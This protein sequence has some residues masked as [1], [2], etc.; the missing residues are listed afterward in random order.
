MGRGGLKMNKLSFKEIMNLDYKFIFDYFDVPL[1][2]IGES[3]KRNYL[4]YYIDDETFFVSELKKRDVIQLDNTKNLKK[5]MEYLIEIEKLKIMKF[6]F[7]EDRVE[8]ISIEQ[9]D[10]DF[11]KYLPKSNKVIDYDYNLNIEIPKEYSFSRHLKFLLETE[12]M[13]VR[14][15]DQFNSEIYNIEVI[16]NVMKYVKKSFDTVKNAAQ[17]LGEVINQ[18]LMMSPNTVGSFK[19]N[20]LMSDESNLLDDKIDFFPILNVIDEVTVQNRQLNLDII[21]DEVG[22]ELINNVR[23]F[24][25]TVKKESIAIEFYENKNSGEQLARLSSNS[26]IDNNL[27][28]FKDKIKEKEQLTVT[29]EEIKLKNSRFITGSVIYNSVKIDVDGV[30]KKAK[31]QTDLF[32]RIK[33][34]TQHLSLDKPIELDLIIETSKDLQENLV[35]EILIIDNFKYLEHSEKD[36]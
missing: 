27:N 7:S 23:E 35:K 26:F 22:V 5:F 1:S 33:N 17:T 12:N 15:T 16:E 32:K 14:I 9:A 2:F 34:K 11:K 30:T 19:I 13:T 4:F 6:D 21:D 20:F 3:K 31:F 8:Y 36:S 29:F 28:V 24:Y 18:D 10:F 25:D